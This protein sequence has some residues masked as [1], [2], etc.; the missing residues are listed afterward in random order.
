VKKIKLTDEQQSIFEK[1][2][3]PGGVYSTNFELDKLPVNEELSAPMPS[4]ALVRSIKENGFWGWNPVAVKHFIEDSKGGYKVIAGN[5]RI[6]A[7]RE[8]GLEN[9]PAYVFNEDADPFLI[10]AFIENNTRADNPHTDFHT[11]KSLQDQGF[12]VNQIASKT[13]IRKTTIVKRL[14]LQNLT[15]D[16]LDA[17]L[18]SAF[19]FN[20]AVK[21]SNWQKELQVKAE[22]VLKA[23]GKITLQ[24]VSEL[25]Q[26]GA[27]KQSDALWR[28]KVSQKLEGMR[29]LIPAEEFGVFSAMESL[30]NEINFGKE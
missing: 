10:T 30:K 25:S 1:I 5:R 12:T 4:A 21:I 3:N 23:K 29:A 7:A 15:P 9:I 22:S 16:L 13:G 8:A 27:V 28:E 18:D 11:L 26:N 19:T 20:T 2:Q 6:M 17:Y 14:R 24:D